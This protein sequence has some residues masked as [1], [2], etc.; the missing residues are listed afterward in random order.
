MLLFK[1]EVRRTTLSNNPVSCDFGYCRSTCL[2]SLAHSH[3]I[4]PSRNV[5][6]LVN[7]KQILCSVNRLRHLR[8]KLVHFSLCQYVHLCAFT[9]V[10]HQIVSAHCAGSLSRD[11]KSNINRWQNSWISLGVFSLTCTETVG[12]I[13]WRLLH[14]YAGVT[15]GTIRAVFLLQIFWFSHHVCAFLLVSSYQIHLEDQFVPPRKYPQQPD[16]CFPLCGPSGLTARWTKGQK[17]C[18]QF[19]GRKCEAAV[20]VGLRAVRWCVREKLLISSLSQQYLCTCDWN[21]SYLDR[22][23]RSAESNAHFDPFETLV[24]SQASFSFVQHSL[25]PLCSGAESICRFWIQGF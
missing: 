5:L 15:Q 8:V 21:Y 23:S 24:A 1:P 18:E 3:R 4:V 13:I 16:D 2:E 7:I 14:T 22:L 20:G 9:R 6:D 19:Q 12:V 10:P 11:S 25:L 17:D